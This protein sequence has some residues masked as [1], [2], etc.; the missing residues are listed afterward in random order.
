MKNT[1]A[2]AMRVLLDA[3]V[4][5]AVKSTSG[6]IGDCLFCGK[7]SAA[8][9]IM[10]AAGNVLENSGLPPDHILYITEKVRG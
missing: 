8:N 7:M 6:T 3:Q 10:D 5:C 9:R 4:N 1:F 2:V